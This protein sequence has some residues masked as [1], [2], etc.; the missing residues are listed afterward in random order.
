MKTFNEWLDSKLSEEVL[1]PGTKVQT[2]NAHG[3]IVDGKIVRY[4]DGKP[5]GSP[6]YVVDVGAYKSEIVPAH[7]IKNKNGKY[8]SINFWPG[9]GEEE[10]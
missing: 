2:L 1:K 8:T 9:A 6:F 10:G 4:E 3:K 5:H 7:K